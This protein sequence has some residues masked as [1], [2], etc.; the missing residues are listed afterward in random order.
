[1]ILLVAPFDANNPEDSPFIAASKKIHLI[2]KTLSKIDNNIVL[3][4]SSHW[5]NKPSHLKFDIKKTYLDCDIKIITPRVFRNR[6]LGKISNLYTIKSIYSKIIRKYGTPSLI[7]IYNGYAFEC[8]FATFAKKTLGNNVKVILEFEDWHFARARGFNPKP[9]ID[10]YY[11]RLLLKH[12]DYSFSVN[13]FL[14]EKTMKYVK[15]AFLLPGLINGQ[16]VKKINN[17]ALFQ[18][19]VIT[20]GYFGGL[21]KEK[22]AEFILKLMNEVY[23]VNVNFIVCGNGEFQSDFK[24][25]S[26][27]NPDI[28]KFFGSINETD[29]LKHYESVDI[30]INPHF[31]NNGVFPFKVIEAIAMNKLLISTKLNLDGFEWISDAIQFCNLNLL[32]FKNAIEN[33]INLYNSKKEKIIDISKKIELNF[34]GDSLGYTISN[35]ICLS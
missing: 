9:F 18:K 4:N 23:N 13:M 31:E 25:F 8:K 12:L 1:M 21:S 27:K 24:D 16:E 6:F 33:S 34:S 20:I 15:Q 2:I 29:L 19:K 14:K 7:W 28:L 30:I 11:W 35:I 22:G 3:I 32:D 17:S 26:L 10:W 5:S